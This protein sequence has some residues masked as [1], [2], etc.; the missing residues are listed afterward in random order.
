LKTGSV[1]FLNG[2]KVKGN[3]DKEDE[4]SQYCHNM[5]QRETTIAGLLFLV[6]KHL[7]GSSK[8]GSILPLPPPTL[9]FLEVQAVLP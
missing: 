1:V 5:A 3:S 6:L 4:G 8:E 2:D 7:A 9:T